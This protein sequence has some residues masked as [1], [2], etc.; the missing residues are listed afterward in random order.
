MTLTHPKNGAPLRHALAGRAGDERDGLEDLFEGCARHGAPGPD[1]PS[2]D[3]ERNDYA[4]IRAA[5]AERE[6]LAELVAIGL[7]LAGLLGLAVVLVVQEL[8]L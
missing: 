5:R 1:C 3:Q 7:A 2:C 8:M 6:K 4:A